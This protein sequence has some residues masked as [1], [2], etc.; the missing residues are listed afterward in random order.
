MYQYLMRGYGDGALEVVCDVV[1]DEFFL[2]IK[3]MGV[4]LSPRL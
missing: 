2:D 4:A 1:R 3:K